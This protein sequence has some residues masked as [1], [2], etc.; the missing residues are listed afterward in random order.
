MHDTSLLQI[1]PA[2]R[3]NNDTTIAIWLFTCCLTIFAMV[4]LGGVTRL[5]GSGLSMV[6]W[7]P[8][9][10]TLPPLTPNQWQEAFILYQQFPEFQLKNF[11]MDLAGFKRIFWFEY[12][13]RLLGRAIGLVFFIPLIY[14]LIKR[15]IPSSLIRPLLIILALGALQGLMGWYMVQSGLIDDPHVS[16]YRLTAHL[17]LAFL[18]YAC[19][20]WL[21][22]NIL[23]PRQQRLTSSPRLKRHALATTVLISITVL[24]GGFVAGLKAGFIYNTFPLMGDRLLPEGLLALSPLWRNVFEN[25]VTVQFDHR[26]MAAAVTIFVITLWVSAG[27]TALSNRGKIGIKLLLFTL[28]LQITLGI[29]TLL[30]EVP[31][32]LAAAHQGGALLL[33]SCTL[34]FTHA[35]YND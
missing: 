18:I 11:D 32:A 24:S 22:L 35:V 34:F 29:S 8:I 10:G 20:F 28:V 15:I 9:M 12:A 25:A 23:F 14:F 33:F 6:T 19:I 13:H 5:T 21:A 3:I 26:V 1:T 7:E 4:V 31:V 2:R 30:L 27:K 17:G 16:Q